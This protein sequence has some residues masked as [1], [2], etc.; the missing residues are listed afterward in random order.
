LSHRDPFGTGLL[1]HYECQTIP[2]G[3]NVNNI[4]Q[5]PDE[6][7]SPPDKTLEVFKVIIMKSDINIVYVKCARSD[8]PTQLKKTKGVK[9]CED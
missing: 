4:R 2:E 9:P 6:K 5:L 8:L 7:K 1:E 3:L